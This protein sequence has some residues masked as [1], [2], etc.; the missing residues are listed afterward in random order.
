MFVFG[1]WMDGQNMQTPVIMGVLGNNAQTP[2]PTGKIKYGVTNTSPG[3]LAYSGFA[4]GEE[5]KLGTAKEK[6]PDEALVTQKPKPA[7]VA[8]EGAA[9]PP[10][11]GLNKFSSLL[12][13]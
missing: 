2:L 13:V 7:D 1:F 3:N 11:V 10:G 12:Y 5:P 4:T 8:K 9:P 6:V